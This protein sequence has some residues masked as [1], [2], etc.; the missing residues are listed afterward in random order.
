[1]FD[2]SYAQPYDCS[3][4]T[5]AWMRVLESAP[6]RYD[7]GIRLLSFGHISSVYERI[8]ELAH[9]PEILDL[10]CG[11]GTLALRL[12]ARG[13]HVT[14]VD[15]S[16]DMLDV[17]REKTPASAAVRWVQAGAV[18][19]IDYFQ[20]Q[21]FDAIISVLLFS[22]LSAS[23]QTE[24]L[25]QCHLLLRPG[26]Q[27]IIAD[28]IR[29]ATFARRAMQNLVRI[30]LAA[31]TYALTQTST[32]AVRDLEQKVAAAQFRIVRRETNHLGDFVLLEALKQE[33]C[34]ATAA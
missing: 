20:P 34:D 19:L 17:T 7:L 4:S 23:E 29:A 28:E 3:V 15:L 27:F 5:Y 30:P 24:T 33:S 6:R 16:P 1:M 9:G 8:V 10:G 14:G 13:L 25:R 31:V 22:E 11:T 18:E 32:G 26:G 12:A 21:R 2:W